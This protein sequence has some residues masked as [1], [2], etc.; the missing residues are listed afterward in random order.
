VS[1]SSKGREPRK[2]YPQNRKN[3]GAYGGHTEPTASGVESGDEPEQPVAEESLLSDSNTG[4]AGRPAGHEMRVGAWGLQNGS[5]LTRLLNDA[6]LMDMVVS[7]MV[8]NSKAVD[9]LARE[10]AAKLREAL[11]NDDELRQ[12]LID[13]L[14][15][16]DKFRHRLV[17]AMAKSIN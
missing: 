10:L 9:N 11:V 7:A 1:E 16:N 6:E 8:A 5:E 2:K 4:E 14:I 3:G 13:V 12:W 17:K 15:L